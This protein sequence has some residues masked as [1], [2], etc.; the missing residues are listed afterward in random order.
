MEVS[1]VQGSI[2]CKQALSTSP[3]PSPLHIHFFKLNICGFGVPYFHESGMASY[4]TLQ[5]MV[6]KT[7]WA[8]IL[9]SIDFGH[10]GLKLGMFFCTLVLNQVCSVYL[11]EASFSSLL[12]RP[13]IKAIH[14]YLRQ[15]FLLK[16]RIPFS[17]FIRFLSFTTKLEHSGIRN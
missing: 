12:V 10:F 7:F 15:H 3:P 16:W 13:S 17:G 8:E 14:N 5:V 6:F 2:D 11:E 9:Q 4:E 1:V